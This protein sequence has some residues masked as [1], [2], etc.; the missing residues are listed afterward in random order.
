[1]SSLP[2]PS[3]T[4]TPLAAAGNPIVDKRGISIA[5]L[6]PLFVCLLFVSFLSL[7]FFFF[8]FF[9]F[10]FFLFFFSPPFL[11]SSLLPL[12]IVSLL[13][14]RKKRMARQAIFSRL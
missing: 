13:C 8:F 3:L 7:F 2:H 14:D 9:F 11:L 1:V 12:L 4:Y 5:C 6:C 10:L